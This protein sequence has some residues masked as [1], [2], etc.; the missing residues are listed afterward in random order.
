MHGICLAQNASIALRE[1]SSIWLP[2]CRP[3]NSKAIRMIFWTG[4]LL[5]EY[6]KDC[7]VKPN[8]LP[9]LK[10]QAVL[11]RDGKPL[12]PQPP[13]HTR[14]RRRT[15]PPGTSG[16]SVSPR[17]S[18]PTGTRACQAP[19][20]GRPAS[21][22]PRLGGRSHPQRRQPR[23]S[24]ASSPCCSATCLPGF[25]RLLPHTQPAPT[26]LPRSY[27]RS[28][29]PFTPMVPNGSLSRQQGLYQKCRRSPEEAIPSPATPWSPAPLLVTNQAGALSPPAP[30]GTAQSE[31]LLQ[32]PVLR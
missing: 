23:R 18:Q 7:S 30:A 11:I 5:R 25:P 26:L 27:N 12:A 17:R 14:A 20:S 2:F 22:S 13:T 3:A 4:C 1:A 8:P 6:S 32:P 16:C 9:P 21:A 31:L 10:A 29:S 28:L 19:R 15:G 24:G